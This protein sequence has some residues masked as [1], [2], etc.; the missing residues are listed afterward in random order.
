MYVCVCV[1]LWFN[2]QGLASVCGCS[3]WILLAPLA[4]DLRCPVNV[5]QSFIFTC[6]CVLAKIFYCAGFILGL[7][8][9]RAPATCGFLWRPLHQIRAGYYTCCSFFYLLANISY[10]AG[11]IS[12]A[13]YSVC[14]CSMWILL[15]PVAPDLR[16]PVNVCSYL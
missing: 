13:L 8:I 14:A 4:P 15:A 16:C 1:C 11:I 10:C 12:R 5:L 6:S 3:M 2:I 7:W 9:P